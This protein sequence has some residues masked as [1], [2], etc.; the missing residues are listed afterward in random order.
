M[1]VSK[2][3]SAS[4]AKTL[5]AERATGSHFLQAGDRAF[6]AGG[7][8]LVRARHRRAAGKDHG[9]AVKRA[10][11][12][13]GTDAVG[14]LDAML[15]VVET[16]LAV[17]RVLR[18]DGARGVHPGR[19]HQEDAGVLGRAA[20]FGQVESVLGFGNEKFDEIEAKVGGLGEIVQVGAAE[21][22]RELHGDDAD[23]VLQGVVLSTV[24][25]SPRPGSGR[26]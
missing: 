4:R 25:P 18:R 5:P 22:T 15:E 10:A 11:D 3:L 19:K 23:W 6:G 26:R 13:P 20:G 16:A 7:D 9:L 12:D 21:G 24:S 14:N 1:S 2:R 8:V 17:G